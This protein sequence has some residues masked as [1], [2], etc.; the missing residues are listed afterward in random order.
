TFDDGTTE[1][2]Y[3]L[4]G[5]NGEESRLLF[6]T[7]PDITPGARLAV[8]GAEAGDAIDVSRVRV[9]GDAEQG[10]PL[11]GV[12]PVTPRKMCV[13]L[14]DIGG[15][16]GSLTA[17]SVSSAFFDGS[18]SVNAFYQENSYGKN[19]LAGTVTGPYSFSMTT[20]DT[21]GMGN[22]IRPQLGTC[23]QYAY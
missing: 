7:A 21:T 8:W 11:I 4:R 9:V 13:A 3:A 15:G 6:H 16:L 17:A 2:N 10:L 18:K 22:A 1:T 20:C 23:D 14:V 5:P 19:S 12:P